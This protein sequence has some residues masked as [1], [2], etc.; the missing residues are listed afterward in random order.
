MNPKAGQ[1]YTVVNQDWD[2]RDVDLPEN[3][4]KQTLPGMIGAVL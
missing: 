3:N 2:K 1:V 4:H